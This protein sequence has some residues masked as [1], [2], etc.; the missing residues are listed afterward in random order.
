M[1][2]IVPDVRF[3]SRREP[4]NSL[5][6]INRTTDN[7]GK[8]DG[9]DPQLQFVINQGRPVFLITNGTPIAELI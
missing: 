4:L 7:S 1:A 6:T 5:E 2:S 8:L 9:I 3:A